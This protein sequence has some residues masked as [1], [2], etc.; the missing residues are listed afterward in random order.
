MLEYLELLAREAA[1]VEFEGPLVAARNAGLPPDRLAELEQAK[2]VALRVRAL[3]ERRRRREEELSGLFDTASDLA[4]LRDVDAVLAA[5]VHRA[6][7]LLG[8]D[9]AYMTLNDEQHGDTYMRVT[10]GSIS[11]KF[12]ALR[13]PMGAGLGGLVAQTG[14]PYVTAN[15]PEDARFRHT[16]DIDAG[17]GE[18]GLVAILGVP[19][20]L[21]SRIIGVLYAANRSARPFAREEVSLLVSLAANAAVA[22]DTARLLGETQAALEELSAANGT[23]RAHSDSV[24][25]AAAAHDRMTALVLRGAGVEDIAEVV[26][27]V[28]GGALLV[29]DADGRHQASVGAL[30]APDA[31][32]IAE[33]LAASR[34]EGRS[35]RR[36]PLWLAAVVAGAENLG[37]LV[38]RPDR[39]LVD[40]DQRILE[41]AAVVTALLLLFRRTVADAEGRVRG[42]LLDDVITRPVRDADSL[43]ARAKRLGVDLDAPNVVVA[44]GE[45]ALAAGS[46]RQRAVSW[47]QTYAQTRGGLAAARD[48]HVVLLLPGDAAGPLARTVARDLGKLLGRPVTAGAGGPATGPAG[49]AAAYRDA[50]RCVIALAALGRAGAGASTAELGFVG[51]LLGSAP[52]GRDRDVD[53]FLGSTIGPVVD[54]DVRR[55]TALVKTLEAYFGVGGSLARAAELLHVHVN[56]VT[57][58]LERIGQLL[59]ADWQKPERAL[60]VQLALRLH[61]LR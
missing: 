49:I 21:G 60:E 19:L 17:V 43:R 39:P 55:G 9:V 11:A 22:I 44:V 31:S 54:Y 23:I 26:T 7:T 25:R 12:Q 20:R 37:A 57:Q 58:R 33:A 5:I 30:D 28:L 18:E 34:T 42:E 51:L 59:G 45:D 56:T 38:L 50:D 15:Y 2:V 52:D 53:A 3:L 35:V 36:G 29:L 27:E 6:R 24:E 14:S 61:R 1:A 10:D 48:G 13:L 4:G 8:A 16:G 41:R 32:A 47:A 40:A 46:A